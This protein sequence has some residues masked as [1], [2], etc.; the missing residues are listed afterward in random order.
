MTSGFISNLVIEKQVINARFA[1]EFVQLFPIFLNDNW[2]L[3]MLVD[4]GL[5][6]F[7]LKG[8]T[9]N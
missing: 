4:G 7:H 9:G 1:D 5:P 3:K 6:I 2:W 8:Y